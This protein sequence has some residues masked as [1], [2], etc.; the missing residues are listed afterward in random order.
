MLSQENIHNG[1]LERMNNIIINRTAFIEYQKLRIEIPLFIPSISSVKQIF[2][3]L[4]I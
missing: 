1:S 3:Q 4:T 2:V